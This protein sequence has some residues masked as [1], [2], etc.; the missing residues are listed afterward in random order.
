MAIV[1][2][3]TLRAG[4]YEASRDSYDI[5]HVVNFLLRETSNPSSVL[6]I[7]KVARD[8]A[9]L[10]QTANRSARDSGNA[11]A[12]IRAGARRASLAQRDIA[13]ITD[14]GLHVFVTEVLNTAAAITGRIGID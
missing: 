3:H 9:R 7:I 10:V 5:G 1:D 11:L 14:E 6:S 8:N 12:A 4:R 2:R 13:T